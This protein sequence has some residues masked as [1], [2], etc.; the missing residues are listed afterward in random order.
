[1]EHGLGG[2]R[3]T[4][5]SPPLF[6]E[7][8]QLQDG[9]RAGPTEAPA[10]TPTTPRMPA[11][12]LK[13]IWEGGRSQKSVNWSRALKAQNTKRVKLREILFLPVPTPHTLQEGFLPAVEQ[14]A[15]SG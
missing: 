4:R 12:S 14:P 11:L 7:S 6:L 1:M 3:G 8:A 9:I 13:W 15:I 10:T 2:H 5:I